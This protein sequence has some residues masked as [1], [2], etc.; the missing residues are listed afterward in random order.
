MDKLMEG[1]T[2]TVS[3]TPDARSQSSTSTTRMPVGHTPCRLFITFLSCLVSSQFWQSYI[4]ITN[5]C[6]WSDTGQWL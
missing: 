6:Q 5:V 2:D 4:Q 3:R 1:R